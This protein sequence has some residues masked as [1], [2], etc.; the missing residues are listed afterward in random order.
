MPSASPS[1]TATMETSSTSELC[2]RFF[3]P[4]ATGAPEASLGGLFVVTRLLGR[5]LVGRLAGL[6]GGLLLGRGGLLALC[7]GLLL[8]R[9]G[10]LLHRGLLGE[11]LLAG[12]RRVVRRHRAL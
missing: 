1:A 3:V 6:R 2:W 4:L 10:L 12:P 7:G 11:L 5:L 8:L 9:R